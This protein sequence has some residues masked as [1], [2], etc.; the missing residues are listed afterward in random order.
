MAS[1]LSSSDVDGG[2]SPLPLNG[3]EREGSLLIG[4]FRM[5]FLGKFFQYL[6]KVIFEA[7]VLGVILA[8]ILVYVLHIGG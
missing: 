4:V 1:N 2:A 5:K 7:I 8:Y 3:V 6:V